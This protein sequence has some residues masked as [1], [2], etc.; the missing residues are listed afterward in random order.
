MTD[1]AVCVCCF[2]QQKGLFRSRKLFVFYQWNS[3]VIAQKWNSIS[4]GHNNNSSSF[5]Q[6]VL[7]LVLYV[8]FYDILFCTIQS[9]N[10][11]KK[12]PDV[13]IGSILPQKQRISKQP[14]C[15]SDKK[16]LS[17]PEVG[18]TICL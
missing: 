16:K 10:L 3:Y 5:Q 13:T 1:N 8:F 15:F 18:V 6:K 14:E 7:C 17:E 12:S 4:N 9:I 11:G 2:A